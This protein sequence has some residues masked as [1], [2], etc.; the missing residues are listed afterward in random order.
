MTERFKLI[1]GVFNTQDA[2]EMLLTLIEQKIRFHELKSFSSEIRVGQA[3]YS[4]L[5]RVDA[6]NTLRSSIVDFLKVE[7]NQ[8]NM[9]S[10]T[11]FIRIERL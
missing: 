9:F 4:S 11:S 5:K 7:D 2:K 1:E 8:L 10:V 3:D 6:L